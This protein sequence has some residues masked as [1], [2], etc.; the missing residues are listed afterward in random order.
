[1]TVITDQNNIVRAVSLIPGLGQIPIAWHVYF[2]ANCGYK[3]PAVIPAEGDTYTE[4]ENG[5]KFT[6]IKNSPHPGA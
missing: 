6:I 2:P 5:L 3:V 1:M 4:D